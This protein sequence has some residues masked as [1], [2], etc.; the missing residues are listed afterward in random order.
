MSERIA[1]IDRV[2]SDPPAV[3]EADPVS[4]L[5]PPHGVWST[6]RDCY[7]FLAGRCGPGSRTLETG[8][9]ISTALFA[10]WRCEHTCVVPSDEE[11]SRLLTYLSRRG[12]PADRLTVEVGLSERVLPAL[13]PT[14]LDLVLIDGGHG[15]PT[16]IIDW[17]YAG[18]RLVEG[19]VLVLDDLLLRSVTAGLL[20]F[21]DADPRWARLAGTAK[22]AAW[23][24]KSSGPLS[25]EWIGQPFFCPVPEM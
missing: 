7:E 25:E 1:V 12:I 4:G 3:H 8:L 22:W 24:R 9:G 11:R 13:E 17:F 10:A 6:D 16:A 5:A 19:G 2:I 21:L 23:R 20:D 18:G 15:F 14:G